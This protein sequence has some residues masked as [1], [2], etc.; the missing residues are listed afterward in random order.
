MTDPQHKMA[1]QAKTDRR[2]GRD[3][4]RGHGAPYGGRERRLSLEPRK[5]EVQELEATPSEWAALFDPPDPP[6]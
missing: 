6:R 3:R 1:G 4:R 5:P 2:S